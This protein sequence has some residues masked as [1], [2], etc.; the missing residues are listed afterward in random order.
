[1]SRLTYQI[2]DTQ[3]KEWFIGGLLPLTWIPLMQQRWGSQREAFKQAMRIES[4]AGC[5]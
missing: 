4:M 1:M 2:H 5:A 3:H